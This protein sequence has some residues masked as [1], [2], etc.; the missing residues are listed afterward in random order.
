MQKFAKTCGSAMKNV[1]ATEHRAS[2][3]ADGHEKN[4][5][6]KHER[7]AAGESASEVQ[8]LRLELKKNIQ[9]VQCLQI[10]VESLCTSV[11][12]E[13][14]MKS[15]SISAPNDVREAASGIEFHSWVP[16]SEHEALKLHLEATS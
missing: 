9:T 16:W 4:D 12:Q 2:Y 5:A 8:E 7:N 1:A 14:L 6:D 3:A 10:Q 15:R 13:K 11:E